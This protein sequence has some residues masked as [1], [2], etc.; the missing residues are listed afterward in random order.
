MRVTPVQE[1]N[2]RS[3]GVLKAGAIGTVAGALVRNFAPLTTDEHAFYFND[4][5]KKAIQ[6]K[7]LKVRSN[8]ISKIA[9]DFTSNRLNITKEAYD[10]F[11]K[12]TSKVAADPK[13]AMEIVKDATDSVKA[14]FKALVHRVDAVGAAKEHIEISNIK[15]AAKSSR[16]LAYFALAGALI[17]MSGQFLVNAFNNAAPKK[18]VNQP[19]DNGSMTMA[20][21]ML[22]GLGSNAEIYFLATEAK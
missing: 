5:A 14:G 6:E 8:E 17:A 10:V 7:V 3:T 13:G 16:P 9:E 20:D 18:D 2:T 1:N 4:S 15:S 11:E 22:E 21:V 19:K 12:S